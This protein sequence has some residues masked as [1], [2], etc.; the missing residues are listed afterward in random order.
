[1]DLKNSIRVIEGFPKKGISFKDVLEKEFDR[2]KT[3][4]IYSLK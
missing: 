4:G 2:I 1:V 3:L